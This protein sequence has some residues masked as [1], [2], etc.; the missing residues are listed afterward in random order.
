MVPPFFLN[1]FEQIRVSS[2]EVSRIFYLFIL[3]FAFFEDLDLNGGTVGRHRVDPRVEQLV[4]ELRIVDDPRADDEAGL[5]QE[6][7]RV[8]IFHLAPVGIGDF[9]RAV[10]LAFDE[11]GDE[12]LVRFVAAIAAIPVRVDPGAVFP[13]AADGFVIERDQRHFL[14]HVVRNDRVGNLAFRAEFLDLNDRNT[15]GTF[16]EVERFVEGGALRVFPGLAFVRANVEFADF[17]ES[18]VADFGFAGAVGGTLERRVVAQNEYSVFGAADVKFAGIDAGFD[19]HFQ[20]RERIVGGVVPVAAVR[21]GVD[22]VG[23]FR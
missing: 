14:H 21:H 13:H 8:R 5:F 11:P 23:D 9:E 1:G 19:R 20:A 7:D 12:F 17:L 6:L 18:H 22:S 10:L 4:H 15:A 16:E 3:R 2:E